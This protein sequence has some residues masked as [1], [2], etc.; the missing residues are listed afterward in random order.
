M[1]EPGYP[2]SV[3]AGEREMQLRRCQG[4]PGEV[5]EATGDMEDGV[6]AA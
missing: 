1:A 2:I 5:V 4:I 3:H 6:R